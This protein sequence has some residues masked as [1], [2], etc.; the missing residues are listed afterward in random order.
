MAEAIKQDMSV[1]EI[2]SSIKNILMD[3]QTNQE[4]NKSAAPKVVKD[5]EPVKAAVQ[6][7]EKVEDTDLDDE[8]FNLSQEME[9]GSAEIDLSI[10]AKPE[11]KYVTVT[12]EEI[13]P[14][15][16]Y[17]PV[18]DEA[19]NKILDSDEKIEVVSED[20]EPIAVEVE[21]E[22]KI[23]ET[24]A[25]E[26]K[27]EEK[28]DILSLIDEEPSGT[29]EEMIQIEEPAAEPVQEE[30]SEEVEIEEI[31]EPAEP[32]EQNKAADEKD[33]SEALLNNFAKMFEEGA[34]TPRPAG[35]TAKTLDG[36]IVASVAKQVN[37]WLDANLAA[38]VTDLV[39]KEIERVKKGGK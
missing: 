17:T 8:V 11:N 6:E 24:P 38:I 25:V 18:S 12:V 37:N 3:D 16:A 32:A 13:K 4:I 1:E 39:Q 23:E 34:H 9:V 28:E 21:P 10:E 35:E 15:P 26:V 36:A 19:I 14:A 22:V 31:A 29:I 20:E 30:L 2:L 33:V 7:E 27:V 5:T